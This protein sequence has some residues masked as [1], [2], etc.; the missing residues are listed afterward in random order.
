VFG[1]HRFRRFL[2]PALVS[3]A[4]FL[5]VVLLSVTINMGNIAL[6]G[7]WGEQLTR[8]LAFDIAA[9]AAVGTAAV[10]GAAIA[11]WR[12]TISE[13]QLL[14]ADRLRLDERFGE[15]AVLIGHDQEDTRIAGLLALERLLRNDQF[16]EEHWT[17]M[18][19]LISFIRRRRPRSGP[20][21]PTEPVE[22]DVNIALAIV[23][24]RPQR[25]AQEARINLSHLDLHGAD[26]RDVRLDGV[27]LS[28]TRLDDVLLERAHLDDADLLRATLINSNLA[29]A[30]LK[31]A[32]LQESV[33]H[34]ACVEHTRFDGCIMNGADLRAAKGSRTCFQ[35]CSAELVDFSG[36]NLSKADFQRSKLKGAG[37]SQAVVTGIFRG[38]DLST[39][40]LGGARLE[41]VDFSEASM[42]GADLTGTT[43]TNANLNKVDLQGANILA[44][45][46]VAEA[47][48]LS[49]KGIEQETLE[50]LR[51]R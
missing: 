28:H 40:R 44:A 46:G 5:V 31:H 51:K 1:A 25:N 38:S 9:R 35:D 50:A 22:G 36:T 16:A 24:R 18:Q 27:D 34:G 3:L 10:V 12:A 39:A 7:A 11:V 43:L 42:R 33:L 29:H 4:V 30:S 45:V 15:A 20:N 26:L 32:Q 13:R 47:Q 49:A 6:K 17:I 19:L 48:L 41:G 23:G 8:E 37:F 21:K 2:V 14:Q